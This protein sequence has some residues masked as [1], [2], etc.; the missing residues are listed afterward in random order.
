MKHRRKGYFL[1]D[2]IVGL[3]LLGIL[4]GVLVAGARDYGRI[5]ARLSQRAAA[6]RQAESV[7][8][9]L[10][11]GQVVPSSPTVQ[12]E[13]LSSDNTPPGFR[14]VQVRVGAVAGAGAEGDSHAATATLT[15]L[16]PLGPTGGRP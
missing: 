7:L 1:A 4:G 10:H 16:V 15:G 13:P 6:A 8:Q 9:Q 2:A 11:A 14:W 12:I 5:D 3:G